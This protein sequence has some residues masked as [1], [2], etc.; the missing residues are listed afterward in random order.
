MKT[1]LIPFLLS[2]VTILLGGCMI[3]PNYVKPSTPMAPSFKEEA[4][5]LSQANDV[6]SLLSRAIKHREETGGRFTAILS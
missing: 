1:R 6:G 3:G 4:P 5:N 2:I